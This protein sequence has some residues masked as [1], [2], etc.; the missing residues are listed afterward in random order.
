ME[1]LINEYKTGRVIAGRIATGAD[2]LGSLNDICKEKGIKAGSVTA[3]GALSKVNLVCYNQ[4]LR[5]YEESVHAHNRYEIASL[6]GNVSLFEGAP[7]VHAH[8]ILSGP[9]GEIIGGHVE[10]KCEV[11]L[12]EYSIT[13]LVGNG[14]ERQFDDATGL[15]AWRIE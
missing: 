5:K 4:T 14:L 7:F 9:D 11:F 13:E 6:V 8:M 12:C 15:N 3:I 10:P 2:L 1:H